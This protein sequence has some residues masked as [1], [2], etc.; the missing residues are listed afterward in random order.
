MKTYYNSNSSDQGD[1]SCCITASEW[2]EG[3]FYVDAPKD[4]LHE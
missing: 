1:G 4:L 3:D 2:T